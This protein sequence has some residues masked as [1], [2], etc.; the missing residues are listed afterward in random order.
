M[1]SK[2]RTNL[3]VAAAMTLGLVGDHETLVTGLSSWTLE[4][5]VSG[6]VTLTS[7]SLRSSPAV[8][9]ILSS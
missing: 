4:A 9:R 8:A 1:V 6:E 7:I 5:G 2:S 3:L